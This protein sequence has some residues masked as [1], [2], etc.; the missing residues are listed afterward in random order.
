MN[1][2]L[3]IRVD[4]A[5]AKDMLDTPQTKALIANLSVTFAAAPIAADKIDFVENG[6]KNKEE[7]S[8]LDD[9]DDI[10]DN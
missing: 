9:L 8:P 4:G 7:R 5:M 10:D 6:S 3:V 1:G 2:R